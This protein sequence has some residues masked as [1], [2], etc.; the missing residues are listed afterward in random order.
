MI[1]IKYDLP[2]PSYARF[3]LSPPF[4]SFT[5]SRLLL[6]RSSSSSSGSLFCYP[7]GVTQSLTHSLIISFQCTVRNSTVTRTRT[8]V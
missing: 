3:D 1:S 6:L 8:H 7:R 2:P 4:L 5:F